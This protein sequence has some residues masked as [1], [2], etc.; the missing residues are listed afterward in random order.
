M[1]TFEITIQRKLGASWPVV[2]L[3]AAS[4]VF[5][6]TRREGVL[7]LDPAELI[8][9]PGPFE[10]GRMLGEAL[11]RGPV[12]DAFVEAAA[13]GDG[14]LH[15]LLF[16]EDAPLRTLRWERLCAPVGGRWDF[17]RL[18]QKTPFSLYLPAATD[19]RFPYLARADLRAL[20]VVAS[21]PVG[22]AFHLDPFD[23]ERTA[24]GVR[25]AL[26]PIPADV[27]AVAPGAV[28]PPT[29]DDL[30]ERITAE[31][32]T[33]LHVVG[34]G[35]AGREGAESVL[36]LL[37]RDGNVDAVTGTRLIERLGRLRGA[38]GLPHLAFLG[39]CESASPE[40]EDA[41][42][43]I[44]QR[45][46]REL[47][48][49]AVIA[50]ADR[51]TVVTAEALAARFYERLG[52]H[53]A[54]DLA[55]DE[56]CAGL[57]ERGDV[58]VPALYS[59][60]GGRK[61]F[62][63]E[64]VSVLTNSQ[65][66]RGLERVAQLLPGRAPI[67]GGAFEAAAG[68]LRGLAAGGA[69]SEELSPE[70]RRD[71][72][73]ALDAVEGLCEEV[74]DLSFPALAR[75]KEPPPYDARCPFPGLLPFHEGED[76]KQEF[77]FGREAL[78]G[79]LKCRLAADRFL[80]VLGASG[81]GKSS[82]VRA[83]LLE[84]LRREAPDLR[85]VVFTPGHDPVGAL[86]QALEG[87]G[88][89][90][91]LIVVDQFEELF[92]L[93]TDDARRKEFLDALLPLRERTRVVLTMR[94]D[95][96]GDC[97]VYAPLR[98]LVEGRQK[99]IA[100]MDAAELRRAMEL[101]CGAVGLRFEAG[102]GGEIVA[103]V[104]GEPGAMPLLQHCLLQLWN[105][106]HGRWLKV[107]EYR[108]PDKV[109][110][111]KQAIARTADAIF[112]AASPAERELMPFLFVRLARIDT[113]A[114]QP[115]HRRDTRRREPL[116]DLTPV[117]GDPELTRRL[118]TR[119]ADA[120][121]L[122]TTTDP[123]TREVSVEVAHEALIRHWKRLRGWLDEA[124]ASERLIDRIRDA[125]EAWSESG[126]DS[127]HLALRGTVLAEAEAL[128]STPARRL[129]ENEARFIRACRAYEDEQA[130]ARE[131]T[132]RR[133]IIGLAAGL[134]VALGLASF[135]GWQRGRAID[136]AQQKGTLATNLE[137]A[138]KGLEKALGEA[139]TR[140]LEV[141][142]KSRMAQAR[143]LA[144][145]AKSESE[146]SAVRGLLLAAAAVEATAP[147]ELP[148]PVAEQVL[149]DLL[150]QV[151]GHPIG[152]A[153]PGEIR[154]LHTM[155]EDRRWLL[156]SGP[157]RTPLLWDMTAPSPPDAWVA[158]T[159]AGAIQDLARFDPKGHWLFLGGLPSDP[160]AKAGGS[161]LVN[162]GRRPAAPWRIEFPATDPQVVQEV[163]FSP[164]G[165]WLLLGFDR[166]P[167]RLYKLDG[168]APSGI[169]REL[170]LERS[171]KE[172][173]P[174]SEP[175][176][177]PGM[178]WLVGR[179]EGTTL[180]W[181]LRPGRPSGKP[182][183]LK[184]RSDPPRGEFPVKNIGHFVLSPDGRCLAA[185][186]AN[187]AP[188]L[189][190]L[191]TDPPAMTTLPLP[192]GYDTS[193]QVVVFSPDGRWLLVNGQLTIGPCLW[194]LREGKFERGPILLGRPARESL[195]EWQFVGNGSR[196]LGTG[197]TDALIW[198][199][200]A[201][202][203]A[204]AR[205]VLK[206]PVDLS[207][208]GRWLVDHPRDGPALLWDLAAEAPLVKASVALSDGPFHRVAFSPDARTLALGHE[209]GTIRLCDPLSPG[210]DTHRFP[211]RDSSDSSF[212][213]LLFSPSG[214][215]LL[216]NQIGTAPRLFDL[217]AP[218]RAG[219][220]RLEEFP[221]EFVSD[222]PQSICYEFSPDESRLV[223]WLW[224]PGTPL[225]LFWRLDA[226]NV[227]AT[228][229]RLRGHEF[230]IS[231]LSFV[232]PGRWLLTAEGRGG[233]RYNNPRLWDLR[234]PR[235]GGLPHALASTGGKPTW[236]GFSPRGRWLASRSSGGILD[237]WDLGPGRPLPASAPG[238]GD[239]PVAAGHVP[240]FS[241]GDRWLLAGT[242]AGGLD[243]HDL[244]SDRPARHALLD[245]GDGHDP[246]RVAFSPAVGWLVTAPRSGEQLW[247]WDLSSG[248]PPFRRAEIP[249]RWTSCRFRSERELVVIA[250]R[251]GATRVLSWD[252]GRG[253][254]AA[255][256]PPRTL[257]DRTG[258]ARFS[259]DGRWIVFTDGELLDL[260]TKETLRLPADLAHPQEA[261]RFSLIKR[262]VG[263]YSVS[264]DG[265]WR[266]T[267]SFPVLEYLQSVPSI[268]VH[269]AWRTLR[270]LAAPP[271]DGRDFTLPE[272]EE[273]V[274][275]GFSP[276][277]RRWVAIDPLGKARIIALD[278]PGGPRVLAHGW[279]TRASQETKRWFSPAGAWLVSSD[280]D[281][282][283]LASLDE[284]PI[285]SI[286]LRGFD[287]YEWGPIHFGA[288]DR[289]LCTV[290][291]G[292]V[293]GRLFLWRTG[294]A[295][296]QA[297]PVLL[298][299]V[300]PSEFGPDGRWLATAREDGLSLHPLAI[301]AL[302]ERARH[303]AGR[304]LTEAEREQ[305]LVT[306]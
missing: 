232:G 68:T 258:E 159:G 116:A 304:D 274:F 167:W 132:R 97:A 272:A 102:L 156:T 259:P 211:G 284:A 96:I 179:I 166:G 266:A 32:Y 74:F 206:R 238:N 25:R 264:P 200:T 201:V 54:V 224:H 220:H 128:L 40:A 170:A 256:A 39:C 222:I 43:G 168:D 254:P 18:Q 85:L 260:E 285:H 242:R 188:R 107:D 261:S 35:R 91:A 50:M 174:Q 153:G 100:P 277:S 77:F 221:A 61:L 263:K 65:V 13:R 306:P 20:I 265:R 161:F 227:G 239:R 52:A 81:S 275:T 51:V 45:L 292:L 293:G 88:V 190:D 141:E 281:R 148:E 215:W 92:T 142:R 195:Y 276:D 181:D 19:S 62:D 90:P 288:E 111:L 138:N 303:L 124:R 38:R 180:L 133:I 287:R 8:A 83:G 302:V 73:R 223:A 202:D 164:D 152:A 162:L 134:L 262:F 143:Q 125:A 155:S 80:A 14:P 231:D 290:P 297:W 72:V 305:F 151:G 177:I 196:L 250:P 187:T 79:E 84:E 163:R 135:A 110:G 33:L 186:D 137:A 229:T 300:W 67:L 9:A 194:G 82:V 66:L 149:R 113:D 98:A 118:V 101:Q 225:A 47:G 57:A 289:V 213:W 145:Q 243:L 209:D 270:N 217:G 273:V 119:L 94:A 122:V 219:V 198:D 267:L 249:I 147:D 36:Y 41:L 185:W 104:Q 114:E 49:P 12:R 296:D 126:D 247:I 216:S 279:D 127:S 226:A 235:S 21:P 37:K 203:P 252:L 199:L 269:D 120:K 70:A 44:G 191:K 253:L 228:M 146:A 160:D 109:G 144:A 197:S 193:V 24:S 295:L 15:V 175:R 282:L 22:N 69:E 207:P 246:G 78:V 280:G 301:E 189:W 89:D 183:E 182:S 129:T 2:V 136:L 95:F 56:A 53:G 169:V 42:G 121:L 46:V 234:D 11:F 6:P 10:Y 251:E 237:F 23:V 112:D 158:L 173:N 178:S 105:R 34:H 48:L 176:F 157:G 294:P 7:E 106:R 139:K 140:R 86:G 233:I 218:D 64:A 117:D 244:S 108:D 165:A 55:L 60:L 4:G 212:D 5:L 63:D 58:T 150:E 208:D 154:T 255:G 17:L 245:G 99:L 241:P 210:R 172:A 268:D 286:T 184:D 26:G 257:A 16:V 31:R 240:V 115:E 291:S 283:S 1:Q 271:P 27:L 248:A 71:H 75:G 298:P 87:A 131:R 171:E 130:A 93:C 3:Q 29:L 76:G 278:G 28:G 192:P 59:R 30:C 123:Q 214:R 205:L 204:G 103:D 230:S 299:G 236:A